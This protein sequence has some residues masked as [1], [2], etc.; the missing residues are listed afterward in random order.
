MEVVRQQ[1]IRN[2][3]HD[4]PHAILVLKGTMR[5]RRGSTE[6]VFEPGM[7][8]VNGPAMHHL[9]FS[10]PGFRCVVLET[11][12]RWLAAHAVSDSYQLVS[13]DPEARAPIARMQQ[14]LQG[15]VPARALLDL[16]AAELFA[17]LTR[18]ERGRR[19]ET[20]AWLLRSSTRSH[21]ASSTLSSSA[22]ESGY[23][24]PITLTARPRPA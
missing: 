21:T 1:R 14:H 18:E 23:A 3:F 5:E 17:M 16:D 12:P 4:R 19:R 9:E 15:G 22:D 24:S 13:S 8:R 2:H 11:E 6:I 20:P 10:G 7:V